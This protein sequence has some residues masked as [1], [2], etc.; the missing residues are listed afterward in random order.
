VPISS[1]P[2]AMSSPAFAAGKNRSSLRFL[3][4][5]CRTDRTLW[6]TESPRSTMR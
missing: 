6:R 5:D 2:E 4:P 1:H 3:V